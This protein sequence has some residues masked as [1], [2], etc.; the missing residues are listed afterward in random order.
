MCVE[1]GLWRL[2]AGLLEMT[3]RVQFSPLSVALSIFA[4]YLWLA[5]LRLHELSRHLPDSQEVSASLAGL[6]RLLA[7]WPVLVVAAVI[8]GVVG[9]HRGEGRMGLLSALAAVGLLCAS[10]AFL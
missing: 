9:W 5:M 8:V 3:T 6:G 2:L 1:Q 10:L 7:A 4:A